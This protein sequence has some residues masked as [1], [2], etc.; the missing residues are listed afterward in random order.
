MLA[1]P[2]GDDDFNALYR[3]LEDF[4]TK[5]IMKHHPQVPAR[6]IARDALS[7][8][9]VAH[10]RLDGSRST[11]AYLRRTARNLAV[12]WYRDQRR[13]V[14]LTTD[15]PAP[16]EDSAEDIIVTELEHRDLQSI[17]K[18][19]P[20]DLQNVVHRVIEDGL[21]QSQVAER[22]GVHPR[23]VSRWLRNVYALIRKEY[24]KR[25]YIVTALAGL[26]LAWLL[27]RIRRVLGRE[28][29]RHASVLTKASGMFMVVGIV[30]LP[31]IAPLEPEAGPAHRP[32]VVAAPTTR[33]AEK[34][35]GPRTTTP[36]KAE[37]K[38]RAIAPAHSETG[39]AGTPPAVL[40]LRNEIAVSPDTGGGRQEKHKI[41]VHALVDEVAI[42][43]ERH[44]RGPSTVHPVCETQVTVC[45]SNYDPAL[46][47]SRDAEMNSLSE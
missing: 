26:A 37:H 7:R 38:A 2:P 34:D 24:N 45:P 35:S 6:E 39:A 40:N 33:I 31:P 30:T 43:G 15:T 41:E 5:D 10:R 8:Y 14:E 25:G 32:V 44:G 23:T 42:E 20:L 16:V 17:V 28:S 21:T 11:R 4:L 19:L 18:N 46:D 9:W 47:S 3:Q 29:T 12:D 13:K 27:Q 36:D 1:T 22:E